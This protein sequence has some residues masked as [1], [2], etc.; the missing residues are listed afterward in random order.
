LKWSSKTIASIKSSQ[1]DGICCICSCV[2]A[3]YLF[4][5]YPHASIKQAFAASQSVGI[6]PDQQLKKGTWA[7]QEP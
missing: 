4:P 3:F 6:V 2:V 7:V 5:S 1:Q